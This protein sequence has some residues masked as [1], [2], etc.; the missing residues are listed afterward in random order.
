MSTPSHHDL[1]KYCK[2]SYSLKTHSVNE[3]DAY[4]INHRDYYVI[5]FTGTEAATLW[6][7]DKSE[8]GISNWKD[9]RADLRFVRHD[10][11]EY[12]RVH[13]G[14]IQGA[15]KW[16]KT[17]EHRFKKDKPIYLTG[18]SKGAGEAA[19]LA[20]IMFLEGFD[21]A[22]VVLFAEPGGHYIGSRKHFDSLN[23]K[24]CSYIY[25]SDIIR[26]MPPWGR[27]SAKITKLGPRRFFPSFKD[28]DIDNY[29]KAT[30]ALKDFC[31]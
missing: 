27:Q 30:G 1:A 23:L 3:V 26:F 13:R 28:H 15:L 18:H 12:G 6:P 24:V 22:E 31:E 17:F 21:I 9:I 16:F 4:V 10:H 2:I 25:G 11:P 8:D 29:I 20:R 19:Q 14:F 5:A 7:W